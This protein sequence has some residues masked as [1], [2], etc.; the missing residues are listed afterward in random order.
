MPEQQGDT[1]GRAML[2]G[3]AIADFAKLPDDGSSHIFVIWEWHFVRC[4]DPLQFIG[5]VPDPTGGVGP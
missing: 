4:L 2:Q 5:R 3:V 1:I